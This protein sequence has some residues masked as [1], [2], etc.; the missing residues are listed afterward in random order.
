M[1]FM[2]KRLRR[3]VPRR[4]AALGQAPKEW[5]R[6]EHAAVLSSEH[7]VSDA[8][9]LLVVDDERTMRLMVRWA[10][11]RDGYRV[12]EATNASEAFSVYQTHL[13]DLVVIDAMMPGLDGFETCR[14]LRAMPAAEQCPILM[15]SGLNDTDSADAAFAAGATD[16]ITKPIHWALLRQRVR[17]LLYA[18]YAERTARYLASHDTLTDLP[19]RAWLQERFEHARAQA[20]RHGQ[21]LALLFVD[22]DRFKFVN[23]SLGHGIGD[24][25]LQQIACRLST[26]LRKT[27]AVAR[28]GGDEFVVLLE[29]LHAAEEAAAVA[30]YVIETLRPPVTI[31]GHEL[32]VTPSVGIAA[33]PHDGEDLGEL[34]KDAE[35]A[36]YRAKAEGGNRFE[37]YLHDMG[38][39][40]SRRWS[41]ERGLRQALEADEFALHYQPVIELGS[42]RVLGAEALLRWDR[43]GE[44]LVPPAEFIPLAEETGLIVPIGERV[45]QL[46]CEQIRR[47][48][49]AR[50]PPFYVA[51]NLSGVQLRQADLPETVAHA[52]GPELRGDSALV[53]EITE[54]VLM[55]N[56][57]AVVDR[58]HA[59]KALGVR[60]CI[61]DFGTGY[62]SLSYLKRFPVEI[63]KID[64]SFICDLPGDNESAAI[65]TL[66]IALAHQLNREVVAE[67]VETPAQAA[68]LHARGC[69]AAQ[70]YLYCKPIP[71]A[72]F[73]AWLWEHARRPH[74][75][76]VPARGRGALK[77]WLWAG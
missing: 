53:L 76:R 60:L 21:V 2:K 56:A 30:R 39:R 36:M 45:L 57:A 14:R 64:R 38:V 70:G 47:W 19:N 4:L 77:R 65:A 34:I 75:E 54:S 18:V 13:P 10:L 41:V 17:R 28:L 46:A 63:I 72:Q 1:S 11:E 22:L 26:G 62:S 35:T 51:V 25:L 24:Q 8:P 9:L 69:D 15:I 37:Y 44:G 67:G 68:I 33:Y 43:P 27:D 23:D 49:R 73:E 55:E 5:R 32:M 50:L 16:F 66:I 29:G 20:Q 74:L 12:L 3:F 31:E 58:L 48:R 71:P 7:R 40:V 59:L 52:L 42:G 6:L 61:D